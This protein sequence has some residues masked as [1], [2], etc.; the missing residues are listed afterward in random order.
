M[1]AI[2]GRVR[3]SLIARLHVSRTRFRIHNNRGQYGLHVASHAA[4][5]VGE[6]RSNSRH[7]GRPWI[8]G[9]QV[10][11]ELSAD[12]G[13]NVWVRKNVIEGALQVLLGRLAGRKRG[14]IQEGL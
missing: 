2:D 7:I 9:H 1:S 13:A 4:T 8:A 14:S 3:I 6:D 5:V 12:K 10:L 11:D